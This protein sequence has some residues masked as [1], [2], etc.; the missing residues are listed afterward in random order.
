MF[1]DQNIAKIN[2]WVVLG[3]IMFDFVSI[4]VKRRALRV[5]MNQSENSVYCS[6]ANFVLYGREEVFFGDY[7]YYVMSITYHCI[8]GIPV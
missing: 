7:Y 3:C 4:R 1:N 2:Y 6:E 8:T 5:E